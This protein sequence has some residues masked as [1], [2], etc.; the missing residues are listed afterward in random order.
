MTEVEFI[1]SIDCRFPYDNEAECLRLIA[2]APQIS[3]NAAFMVLHELAR[4]PHS[5]QIEQKYLLRMVDNWGQYFSHPLSKALVD[6][7]QKMICKEFVPL[8]A[9]IE[10]MNKISQ[11]PNEYCALSI[12]YFSC[13]DPSGKIDEIYESIE[14]LWKR[15][16]D[17]T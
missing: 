10:L 14:A 13:D 12:A 11:F 17:A 1:N 15:S 16:I 3:T 6:V 5:R 7:A 9:S 2:M 4:V 8:N